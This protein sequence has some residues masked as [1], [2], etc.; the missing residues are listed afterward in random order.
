[1]VVVNEAVHVC[2][3]MNL[4]T[5]MSFNC[6]WNEEVIAQFYATLYVDKKARSFIGL[7]KAS[8]CLLAIVSLLLFL[9]FHQRI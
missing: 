9:N 1:M 6:D 7:F 2:D 3:R 8:R 5:I 4:H